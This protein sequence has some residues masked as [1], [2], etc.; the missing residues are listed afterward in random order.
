[1]QLQDFAAQDRLWTL[2]CIRILFSNFKLMSVFIWC[3]EKIGL[4]PRREGRLSQQRMML[5]VKYWMNFG[6][7]RGF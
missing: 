2:I 1:M 6:F 3:Y 5:G 7:I 4:Y